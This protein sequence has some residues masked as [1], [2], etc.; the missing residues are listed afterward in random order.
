MRSLYGKA[1]VALVWLTAVGVLA[2][3]LPRYQCRCPDG[4]LKL[5]CFGAS[6]QATGCCCN[7]GCCSAS[8]ESPGCRAPD[9][10]PASRVGKAGCCCCETHPERAG[11]TAPSPYHV[12]SLGCQKT[13]TP[14]DLVAV[15][16]AQS[17]VH[18]GLDVEAFVP[19]ADSPPPPWLPDA[20]QPLLS[21]QS[22]S[23]PPPTDLV[24]VHLHLVI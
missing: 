7:G 14:S 5:F 23:I 21:W 16:P 1:W 9:R 3:G 12:E 10:A 20:T 6:S 19:P 8:Q 15:A 17:P 22:Y 11:A 24:I 4:R 18:D 13:L 2:A